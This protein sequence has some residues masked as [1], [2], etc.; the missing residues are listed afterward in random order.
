MNNEPQDFNDL[1]IEYENEL[2]E[3]A[4]AE[5]ARERQ[6]FE[7]LPAAERNKII[8]E[9]EARLAI[10]AAIDTE[11]GDEDEE[12]EDEEDGGAL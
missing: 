10:F 5:I 1:M 11:D 8:A 3:K 4:R 7:R 2:A 9:R 12:D 6:A